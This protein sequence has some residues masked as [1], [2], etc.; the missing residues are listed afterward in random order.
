MAEIGAIL[1]GKYEILE[2]IG[3]GGT[4]RV[5]LAMDQ[6]LKKKWAIKEIPQNAGFVVHT[7]IAE[8]NIIKNFDHPAIV[9][10]VDIF[11]T[12]EAIYLVE[13]YIEGETLGSILKQNGAQPQE[14]VVNWGIQLCGALKYLHSRNPVIIYRDMKPSNIM[15]TPSGTIKII[16]F[17]IAREYKQSNGEDTTLLGTRGYAAPEQ[18]GG[19][20]QT[21]PRTDIYSL[22]VTLYHLVTG[23]NPC[24]PPYELYPIRKWNPQL[25]AGLER[26]IEKC[27]QPDPDKR[28]QSCDELLNSLY[29]YGK[30][31]AGSRQR[32]FLH[33]IMLF[34]ESRGMKAGRKSFD[35]AGKASQT[36]N[37]TG[38]SD[39]RYMAKILSTMQ[40]DEKNCSTIKEPDYN[41]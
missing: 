24:E 25:S 23:Q 26:I 3:K 16:D 19:N 36:D 14:L 13:D 15:L 31:D 20:G 10:I 39:A 29:H 4:A 37:G 21:D 33:T 18:Y 6:R 1:D 11:E 30:A 9:R 8:A 5:Y 40:K 12:D 17:G 34:F 22:G 27:T 41:E 38:L 7:A 35:N 28:Y 2:L 32:R